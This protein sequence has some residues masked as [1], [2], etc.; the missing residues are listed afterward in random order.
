VELF[1]GQL[2]L[3][4][5]FA[6]IVAAKIDTDWDRLS[7]VRFAKQWM[8]IGVLVDVIVTSMPEGRR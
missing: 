6:G 3:V 1:E 2:Q 5:I 7:A 8:L 4:D